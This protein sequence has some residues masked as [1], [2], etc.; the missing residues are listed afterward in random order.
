MMI[1]MIKVYYDD[2]FYERG[3]DDLGSRRSLFIISLLRG[4]PGP[5]WGQFIHT[6]KHLECVCMQCGDVT[7]HYVLIRYHIIVLDK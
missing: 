2:S 5:R 6:T 3:K 1:M 4:A 7:R